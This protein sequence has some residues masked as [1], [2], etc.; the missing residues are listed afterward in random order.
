MNQYVLVAGNYVTPVGVK[1]TRDDTV[2]P[3]AMRS[4]AT[5]DEALACDEV[6]VAYGGIRRVSDF[7]YASVPCC[8]KHPYTFIHKQPCAECRMRALEARV[9]RLE[10]GPVARVYS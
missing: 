2:F 5:L 10:S 4:V 6:A 3:A 9:A 8:K 1:V 7:G